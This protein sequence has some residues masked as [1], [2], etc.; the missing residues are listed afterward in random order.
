MTPDEF[1]KVMQ[2]FE[3]LIVSLR[4]HHGFTDWRERQAEK[5]ELVGSVALLFFAIA[6]LICSLKLVIFP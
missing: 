6:I 5:H 3:P 2:E 1:K 4:R